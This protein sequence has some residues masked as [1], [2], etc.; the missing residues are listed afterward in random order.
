V[1][2]T[3]GST[4]TQVSSAVSQICGPVGGPVLIYNADLTN[5]AYAG[6]SNSIGVSTSTAIQPLTCVI[7]DGTRQI[8]GFCPTAT[9]YLN[10]TPGG[11]Y[12][13]PSPAQVAAQI[14]ALGLATAALQNTQNNSINA[15]PATLQPTW[16]SAFEAFNAPTTP[17]T[18]EDP[19]VPHRIW[20]A[21]CGLAVACG[22]AYAGG[23]QMVTCQID[24]SD[25][26]P[27][28]IQIALPLLNPTTESYDNTSLLFP[29]PL[30]KS[31]SASMQLNINNDAAI[32]N[33]SIRGWGGVIYSIP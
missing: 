26:N 1:P 9:V 30:Q 11:S 10:V 5:V 25:G 23:F 28:I 4:V 32:T 12:Q 7:M 22:G 3:G 16:D 15:L 29:T 8:Y 31:G 2:T 24:S 21:W 27:T 20:G 33:A 19:G 6:Y 17:I 18:L 13:S 14:S